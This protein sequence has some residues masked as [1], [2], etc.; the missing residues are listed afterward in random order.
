MNDVQY[1][2]DG[3]ARAVRT[4]LGDLTAGRRARCAAAARMGGSGRSSVTR[5]AEAGHARR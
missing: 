3:V 1:V 2:K 5:S 4:T